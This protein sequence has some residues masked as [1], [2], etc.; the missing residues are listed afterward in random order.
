MAVPGSTQDA[1]AAALEA[2]LRVTARRR[3]LLGGGLAI[4]VGTARAV[5]AASGSLV[6]LGGIAVGCAA[7]NV[8]L[9]RRASATGAWPV[10]AGAVLDTLLVSAAALALGP[11]D[12]APL[13]LLTP[14]EAAYSLSP[15]EGWQ[16]LALNVAGLVVTSLARGVGVR[17]W[18]LQ[19]VSLSLV[20]AILIP[21]FAA[22]R[23]RL[24]AVGAALADL[25]G[26]N[27]AARLPD[28]DPDTLGAL[29]RHVN[30]ALQAIARALG[31]A[32]QRAVTADAAGRRV[33][34]RAIGSHAT[35]Q[36]TAAAAQTLATAME[37][38]RVS[39]DRGRTTADG[40][41]TGAAALT[42]HAQAA[43]R[44][45]RGAADDARTRSRGARAESQLGPLAASIERVGQAA[46]ALDRGSREI[47]K[48]V[49]AITRIASQTDLLALNAAIEAA[50]AG[51]HGLGF[52][53][54]AAEVRKLA[55]Q[56]GRA[57]QE[58]RGRVTE[59][60]AQSAAVV[61][62]LADARHSAGGLTAAAGTARAADEALATTLDAAALTVNA[63]AH[64]AEEHARV[65]EEVGRVV[66]DAATGSAEAA[67]D[68]ER[69]VSATADSLTTVAELLSEARRAG[70]ALADSLT[71]ISGLASADPPEPD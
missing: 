37:H 53:V 55:E 32:R 29:G 18:V 6:L 60:Q 51:A 50:R 61:A 14:L 62:A 30:Q 45:V 46:S 39:L 67:A 33:A 10:T 20:C 9:A 35:A 56:A 58:A 40:A 8:L 44:H 64:E 24:T 15:R 5:G 12:L 66:G 23:R 17:V 13:F 22:T 49:D 3:W 70:G 65:L 63:L 28:A 59:V 69:L 26:G 16:A 42:A 36:A 7:G 31:L 41:A 52:R 2:Y 25:E 19:G 4:A 11:G 38:G 54:V 48:L 27:L 34:E 68:A 57:A 71:A 43:D 21:A 47:A 1:D